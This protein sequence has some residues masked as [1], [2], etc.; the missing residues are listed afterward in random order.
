MRWI[1][2]LLMLGVV[3]CDDE[4]ATGPRPSE[5]FE[6]TWS[7]QEAG[8]EPLPYEVITPSATYERHAWFLEVSAE[9]YLP[10]AMYTDSLLQT[11]EEAGGG[12]VVSNETERGL[13]LGYVN[14]DTV[15]FRESAETG[16][17]L[18]VLRFL[19]EDATQPVRLDPEGEPFDEVW[20][21]N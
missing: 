1:G 5:R 20:T 17:V 12:T 13:L 8:G 4:D 7:L 6:G 15:L 11:V 18:R 14:G 2:L 21:R 9:K 16:E 3:A 19:V 10:E